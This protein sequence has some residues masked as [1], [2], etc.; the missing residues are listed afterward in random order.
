MCEWEVREAAAPRI[1]RCMI[2]SCALRSMCTV[3]DAVFS[4]ASNDGAV[5]SAVGASEAAGV[6]AWFMWERGSLL[7]PPL[8]ASSLVV[9]EVTAVEAGWREEAEE[10]EGAICFV[11]SPALAGREVC[12]CWAAMGMADKICCC[13]CR[14]ALSFFRMLLLLPSNILVVVGVVVLAAPVTSV[15]GSSASASRSESDVENLRWWRWA[16][17][18]L[19]FWRLLLADSGGG[20]AEGAAMERVQGLVLSDVAFDFLLVAG[21]G[22]LVWVLAPVRGSLVGAASGSS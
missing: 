2:R 18:W 15:G 10:V 9:A 3:A 14:R 21:V 8:D 5:A 16:W 11:L 22:G 7:M 1:S 12:V 13:C 6:L 20:L 17:G 4:D 19:S